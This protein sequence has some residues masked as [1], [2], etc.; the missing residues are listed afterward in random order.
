MNKLSAMLS[1]AGNAVV[2]AASLGIFASA[3]AA[4]IVDHSNGGVVNGTGWT[5]MGGG[6]WTVWDDFSLASGASVNGISYFHQNSWAG[7][8]SD[9]TLQIG[10]AAGLSDIFSTTIAKASATSTLVAPS[11]MRVDASFAALNLSAG[12]YWL[13]FNSRDSLHGSA[14]VAGASLTQIGYGS[15][16]QREGNASSFIL[17]GSAVAA[18][19]P[20]PGSLALLGLGLMGFVAARRQARK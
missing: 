17:S 16:Y 14:N 3:H 11:T 13:T 18:A 4:V 7:G 15:S 8:T 20:E 2:L 6:D 5:N 10:T 1:V 12:T 19:V 9:Y